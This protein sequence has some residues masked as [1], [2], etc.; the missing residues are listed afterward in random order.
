MRGF[1]R[2]YDRYYIL[3]MKES[4]KKE[5]GLDLRDGLMRGIEIL[6]WKVLN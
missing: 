6:N 2:E 4:S 3:G 5:G 1:L